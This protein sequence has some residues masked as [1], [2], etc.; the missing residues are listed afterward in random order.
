M[1]N[2]SG[3]G[4]EPVSLALESGFLTT[5]PLGLS[6]IYIFKCAK[7]VFFSARLSQELLPDPGPWEE[8]AE[9]EV[10]AVKHWWEYESSQ[11]D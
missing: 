9:E 10:M 6:P 1:W 2:L 7:N 3:P 8:W 11:R 4:I 5:G